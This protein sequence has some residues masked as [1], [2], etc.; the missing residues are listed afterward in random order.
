MQYLHV[1]TNYHSL[2]AHI[3]LRSRVSNTPGIVRNNRARTAALTFSSQTID[4][5]SLRVNIRLLSNILRSGQVHDK[6][7]S[8]TAGDGALLRDFEI[9]II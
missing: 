9:L 7:S 2:N 4:I 3:M 1:V 6:D 8:T 5:D